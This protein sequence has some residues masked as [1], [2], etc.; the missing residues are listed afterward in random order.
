MHQKQ[1]ITQITGS[2]KK[3]EPRNGIGK[4]WFPHHSLSCARRAENLLLERVRDHHWNQ[5]GKYRVGLHCS[6]NSIC[7]LKLIFKLS[8]ELCPHK[9]KVKTHLSVT[10]EWLLQLQVLPR[11]TGQIHPFS[12]KPLDIWLSEKIFGFYFGYKCNIPTFQKQK[13]IIQLLR[14]MWLVSCISTSFFH[15]CSIQPPCVLP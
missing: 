5:C 7:C 9:E 2:E 4:F 8:L 6:G 12:F 13:R 14:N 1:G 3:L 10:L 15:F 11:F